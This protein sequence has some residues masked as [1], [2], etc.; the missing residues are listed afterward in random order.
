MIDFKL[1][2]KGYRGRLVAHKETGL[3]G[4]IRDKTYNLLYEVDFEY[5]Q[6]ELEML[7]SPYSGTTLDES[8]KYNPFP[9]RTFC[10]AEQLEL[11]D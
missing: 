11:L 6:H 7:D 4:R 8:V 5:E 2:E 9:N 10:K 3:I 1:F